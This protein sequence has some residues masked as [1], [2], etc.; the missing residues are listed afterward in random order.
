MLARLLELGCT[1]IDYEM[2]RDDAMRRLIFFGRFAGLAGMIDSLWAL[3]QR[4]EREDRATPL[5]AIRPAHTYEN[6]EDAKEAI[7]SAGATIATDGLTASLAPVIVGIAGYGN[8]AAGVREILSELPTR[9]IPPS[10]VAKVALANGPSRRCFYQV[11]YR[12]EDLVVPTDPENRFELQDYYRRPQL[13]SSCFAPHL[14]HLT[15]LMNC[16]YWDERYPRLVLN[17]DLNALYGGAD[18]PRLRVIGDLSCDVEGAVQCTKRCT[19]PEDPVYVYDPA[20]DKISSGVD[21]NGPVILAVD[22]LPSELPREASDEF[23]ETLAHFLPAMAHADYSVPFEEL[24]LP[25][26]ILRAVIVHRGELTP[27]YRHLEEYLR[28]RTV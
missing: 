5:A 6:L 13:Y 9:E 19:E 7:R 26:E 16:N 25:P 18:R 21:G 23:G 8:V 22:I 28:S 1:L 14:Q 24:E 2:V 10:D 3:G 15:V 27:E 4:L 12:E 17:K 11:T 20:T